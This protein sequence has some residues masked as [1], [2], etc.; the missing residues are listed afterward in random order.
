MTIAN[1]S[2]GLSPW[3]DMTLSGPSIETN[4]ATDGLF[5]DLQVSGAER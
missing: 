4:P 3:T 2:L 5:S 1:L